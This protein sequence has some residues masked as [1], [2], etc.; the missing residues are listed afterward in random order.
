MNDFEK[1][2][3]QIEKLDLNYSEK[4]HLEQSAYNSIKI[5]VPIILNTYQMSNVLGVK[6]DTLKKMINIVKKNIIILIS[7]K[8]VE[9]KEKSPCQNEN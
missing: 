9:E 7:Q 2:L 1:I 8:E 3:K 6:W 5:G 4:E